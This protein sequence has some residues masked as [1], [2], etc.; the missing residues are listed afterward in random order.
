MQTY[1]ATIAVGPGPANP[2]NTYETTFLADD[3]EHAQEQ[4]EDHVRDAAVE[5]VVDVRASTGKD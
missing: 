1:I 5:W 2:A 3:L 4:A